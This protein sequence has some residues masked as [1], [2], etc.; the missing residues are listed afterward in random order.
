MKY[1]RQGKAVQSSWDKKGQRIKD[2]ISKSKY[3]GQSIKI[4]VSRTRYQDQS[5]KDKV[6]RT[7]Y[8]GQDKAVEYG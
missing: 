2:K 7:K 8:Q 1:Q 3:Q 6:S 5:I 4:K